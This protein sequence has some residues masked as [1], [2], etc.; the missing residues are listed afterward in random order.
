MFV[1]ERLYRE[2]IGS[3][4]EITI[5]TDHIER[6]TEELITWESI[7]EISSR[8]Q[9]IGTIRSRSR[10]SSSEDIRTDRRVGETIASVSIS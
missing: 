2:S 7:V 9:R 1:E 4:E 5:A 3:S 6:D 8:S 10:S